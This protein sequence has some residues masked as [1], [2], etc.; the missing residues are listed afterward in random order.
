[1]LPYNKLLFNYVACLVCT[2]KTQTFGETV[3]WWK[4]VKRA[5]DECNTFSYLHSFWS[6]FALENAKSHDKEQL[7]TWKV[8]HYVCIAPKRLEK[9]K[10]TR[11]NTQPSYTTFRVITFLYIKTL[12]EIR[13]ASAARAFSA[14]SE[15]DS[16]LRASDSLRENKRQEI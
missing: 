2:K 11:K 12:I 8:V 15:R 10:L 6:L 13:T 3:S 4:P 16:A 9:I 5:P 14:T 7:I 1:M